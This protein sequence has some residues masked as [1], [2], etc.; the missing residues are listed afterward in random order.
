MSSPIT[1]EQGPAGLTPAVQWLLI[2]NVAIYF[3]QQTVVRPEDMAGMF[4][5]MSG[6]V[7]ERWWTPLTYA[8][9][10]GGIWHIAFNMIALWQFGP[11]VEQL[12]GTT[13]FVRFYALC[14]LGGAAA[15][16]LFVR[17]GAMV[18]ASAAV[19][20]VMYAF[21][22]AWPRTMLLFFG[23]IPMKVRTY[24]YG[25]A[26]ISL[27]FGVTGGNGGVA[28]F[29]HLGGF[30]TAMLLVRLPMARR[31]GT[32]WQDRFSPSPE[33]PEDEGL[34]LPRSS[35]ARSPRS[36]SGDA[37]DDVVARSNA[38]VQRRPPVAATPRPVVTATVV[39][40]QSATE[41]LNALLDKMSS[42]GG[43]ASLTS[44]EQ[45]RLRE[46][47]DIMRAQS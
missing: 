13:R 21:A 31:L 33:L 42:G 23:V 5:F 7:I 22:H 10:H 6:N 11:R 9:V 27:I 41:E 43:R 14:A 44:R 45:E 18:G 34:R 25:F 38:L 37:V 46:L 15:H 47:S 3:L 17:G 40:V 26:L 1:E 29:A 20:G 12:L 39:P 35:A 8:F 4:A 32:S 30:V 28:H 19:F 24:V 36:E 16:Y 2:A